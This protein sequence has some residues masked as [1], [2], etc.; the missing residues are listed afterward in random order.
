VT[1]VLFIIGWSNQQ[2]DCFAGSEAPIWYKLTDW[3]SI[4]KPRRLGIL[5]LVWISLNEGSI[6]RLI[7]C[8]YR[9]IE[10]SHTDCP[11]DRFGTSTRVLWVVILP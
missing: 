1:L 9:L 3:E 11:S 4:I 6:M 10:V 2:W 5:N 8:D 7:W